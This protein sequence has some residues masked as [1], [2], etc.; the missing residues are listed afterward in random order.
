MLKREESVPCIVEIY[1]KWLGFGLGYQKCTIR[2]RNGGVCYDHYI[3][4][5]LEPEAGSKQEIRG[6]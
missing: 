4:S 6:C 3:E 1:K 2:A 5:L